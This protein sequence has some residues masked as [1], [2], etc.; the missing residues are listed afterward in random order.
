MKN[1]VKWIILAVVVLIAI[2]VVAG[3][4]GYLR[5]LQFNVG[6]KKISING[7]FFTTEIASTEKSRSAGLSGRSELCAKCAML[8]VFERS[9]RYSF[10]MKDMLFD[11]DIIWINGTEIV[12]I[13]KNISHMG[14]SF[15]IVQ[16]SVPINKVLEINAGKSDEVGIKVGDKVK[17]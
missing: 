10:W 9:D 15:E 8:F 17:F 6:T 11:L 14:G 2:F 3:R 16:P 12:G 13:E 4:M 7:H 1:V 5:N